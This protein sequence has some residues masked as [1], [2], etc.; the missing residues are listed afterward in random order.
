MGRH[1]VV[2]S[3]YIPNREVAFQVGRYF[4]KWLEKYNRDDDIYI[5][6]NEGSA[7]EWIGMIEAAPLNVTICRVPPNLSCS[8]DVAGY[9]AALTGLKNSGKTYDYVWFGH[10]KGA[11]HPTY[12]EGHGIREHLEHTFWSQKAVVEAACD[13][14]KFGTFAYDYL[15]VADPHYQT[16]ELLKSLYPSSVANPIGYVTL[17]SFFGITGQALEAFLKNADPRFFA[18]NLVSEV[19]LNRYFFEAGFAWVSDMGGYEPY[20]MSKIN[21]NDRSQFCG[22]SNTSGN[23]SKV[24]SSINKWLKDKVNYIIT[25]YPYADNGHVSYLDRRYESF[26]AFSKDFPD[27]RP[28]L[29]ELGLMYRT[30]KA[31]DQHDMLD[32][33]ETYLSKHRD[34]D[35]VF[36]QI[37]GDLP[38]FRT[39]RTYFPKARILWIREGS[40]AST[41][42]I[43]GVEVLNA[44]QSDQKLLTQIAHAHRPAVIIDDGRH[45]ANDQ[46]ASFLTLFPLL[47][48]GGLYVVED[49]HTLSHALRVHY[50]HGA[51]TDILQLLHEVMR[52]IAHGEYGELNSVSELIRPIAPLVSN[53]SVFKKIAFIVR[54]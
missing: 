48:S 46:V 37:G 27:I 26:D 47:P 53:I 33:Y 19:G 10:T 52:Y 13:P 17:Y 1:A 39:W 9:Q 50:A 4:L 12:D 32:A 25:P 35:I 5:G 44:S 42:D 28:S 31:S 41:D 2:F 23:A 11:T 30:D 16:V 43:D 24:S 20:I 6:V 15:P 22:L 45:V 34:N 29:N 21:S 14:Q 3:S 49:L 54:A 40:A 36:A 18:S 7:D 8:S 38:S 51:K